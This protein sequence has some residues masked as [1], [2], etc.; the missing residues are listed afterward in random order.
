MTKKKLGDLHI[1]EFTYRDTDEIIYKPRNAYTERAWRFFLDGLKKEGLDHLPGFV[2]TI[3]ESNHGHTEKCVFN[4]ETDAEH[5]PEYYRR[6]GCLLALAWLLHSNDL[7]DEN[8]I[9]CSDFPVLV[10]LET[11][12][13]GIVE[14]QTELTDLSLAGSVTFTHLLP[15]FD[16]ME[17]DSGFSGIGGQNLP[18]ANGKSVNITKYVP[19]LLEGFEETFQF[20]RSHQS[21][22]EKSLSL[23]DKCHFRVILRPTSMYNSIISALNNLPVEERMATA[24]DILRRA[25]EKDIDPNMINKAAIV[26]KA[27]V[28]ALTHGWIPLFYTHGNSKDLYCDGRQL[29][30]ERNEQT[31]MNRFFRLS[32]VDAARDRL[33]KMS[34]MEL[35]KQTA[36]I[37][38]VYHSKENLPKAIDHPNWKDDLMH[39]LQRDQIPGLPGKYIYLKDNSGKGNW[40]SGGF[41]LYEGATG[42]L[43]LLAAMQEDDGELFEQLHNDLETYVLRSFVKFQL[44]GNTCALGS[45]VSGIIAG[46]IHVS[47]LTGKKKYLDEAYELLDRFEE[48]AITGTEVDV[49]GGLAGLCLQLSKL[50]G[51]KSKILAEILLPIMRKAN[52]KLTGAGHGKAGIALAMGA[53]QHTLETNEFDERILQL[54]LEE[55]ATIIPERNNWPDLRIDDKVSFMGGWCSGAPGIGMYRKKMMNYTANRDIIEI[56]RRD[57]AYAAAYLEDHRDKELLRDTLCCGNAA[58]LMAAS[59]LG[60]GMPELRVSI[61]RSIDPAS[62][63]LF[64]LVNTADH[65]ISLMQGAA[66]IG[67]ALAMYGN[68]KSGGMLR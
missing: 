8:L 12:L 47:E 6:C 36:I 17:D 14:R 5:L 28:Y 3:Q 52:T 45:G 9:A 23:F 22:V 64:H 57:M 48:K 10:D 59:Y 20:L 41:A 42:I 29:G 66:G 7:H 34:E 60:V 68:Q 67:Y 61:T 50:P 39:I 46:L 58:R 26:L 18:I 2:C 30:L 32:P 54:L 15:S 16:G 11:L 27:E 43:C 25:Y 40:I 62:P 51:K 49:L 24:D 55:D 44:N 63:G 65:R 19:Q 37:R 35:K 1:G 31:V 38:M 4:L 21:F 13:S 53:L 33:C 56:C